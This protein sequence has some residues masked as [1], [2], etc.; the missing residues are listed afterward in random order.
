ML[1]ITMYITMTIWKLL[2]S[3]TK[4]RTIM[5]ITNTCWGIWISHVSTYSDD[6][7]VNQCTTVL[8]TIIHPFLVSLATIFKTFYE[9]VYYVNN[10]TRSHFLVLLR[11]CQY[12][13]CTVKTIFDHEFCSDNVSSAQCLVQGIHIF[14]KTAVRN[15][16]QYKHNKSKS[17]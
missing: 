12:N 2:I 7:L 5:D 10:F 11:N 13:T 4:T 15:Y 3:C 16:L 1:S 9:P 6:F 17:K 14:C 8:Q